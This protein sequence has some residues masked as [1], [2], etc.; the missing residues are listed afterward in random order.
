MEREQL[1]QEIDNVTDDPV[2]RLLQEKKPAS[3]GTPIAILALLVAMAAVSATGW[4]WW[5]TRLQDP[6]EVT[7][8]EAMTQLQGRQETLAT[9]LASIEEQLGGAQS[10]IDVDELSRRNERLKAV[11]SQLEGLQGQTGQDK[12]SVDAMQGSVR[13]LEQRLSTAE[14]GLV[15][16]AAASQN[17]SAALD[18]A[19]IDF[20][21]R[22]ATDRLQL[23]A[24][25]VAADLALQ[26][27][28]VQ[29]EALNDPMYL[30]V[31]Q[32][33]AASRQALARVPAIDRVQL[34]SRI[35]DLQS[36]VSGLPFHG[37]D[38]AQPVPVLPDDAG[39]W[40]SFKHTL[41]SLVTVRRRVPEDESLL[42]LEDKDYLRQG[43]WL[44]FESARL[45]LMRNDSGVYEGSLDRVTVTVEQFFQSGSSE[46]EALLLG[47]ATLKQVNIT[48][49]L[50]DISGPW[51]QLRQLR[52]SRRLL[53]SATPVENVEPEE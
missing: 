14:S 26:A 49:E 35:T 43:L 53:Q 1:N 9:S 4:Q 23:F 27:A 5:Q 40:Q 18:I 10:P 12:A 50:P 19:E 7:Q 25:P 30:S 11:E 3:S 34:T 36:K 31:R 29:I 48:P 51:T 44:Q 22:A 20:L 13:S 17:S 21:L 28:D 46:V 47:V 39:W 52:D 38:S 33:I 24:D 6:D 42:S 15:S 41:S 45:A 32:R 16:V 2:D 37:E 8:K